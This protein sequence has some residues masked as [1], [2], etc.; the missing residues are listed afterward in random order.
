MLHLI[1]HGEDTFRN[2]TRKDTWMIS[3]DALSILWEA[4]TQEWLQSLPCPIDGWPDRTWADRFVKFR[5]AYNDSVSQYYKNKLCGDSPEL[6]PLDCRLFQDIKEGVARNVA[7]TFLLPDNDP[8]K[9][10]LA[11]PK[12]VY[13]SIERTIRAGCPTAARIQQ[14]IYKLRE[15][16]QRIIAANGTYI[17]DSGATRTG[18]RADIFRAHMQQDMDVDRVIPQGD[19]EALDRFNKTVDHMIKNGV[20]YTSGELERRTQ[21]EEVDSENDER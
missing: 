17:P 9:Y 6:M 19:P 20:S 8:V 16:R 14:D 18:D 10:S 4:K 21:L 2:T 7:W 3:H 13:H 15:T 11:S 1:K 12:K 5:G